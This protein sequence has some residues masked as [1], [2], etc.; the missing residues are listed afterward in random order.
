[1]ALNMPPEIEV[2]LNQFDLANEIIRGAVQQGIRAMAFALEAHVKVNIQANGLIDTSALENS[3]YSAFGW[4]GESGRDAAIAAA[5]I[6]GRTVGRKSGRAH[7]ATPIAEEVPI[8]GEF[9]AKVAAC[10]EYAIYLEFGTTRMEEKPF[11]SPAVAE[12]YP[13]AYKFVKDAIDRAL[14]GVA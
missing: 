2:S 14:G 3:V 1:M 11:M 10:V 6:A 7:K 12:I 4:N 9:V 5:T 13:L 8:E